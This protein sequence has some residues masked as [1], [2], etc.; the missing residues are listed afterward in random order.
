MNLLF[1][2]NLTVID[3]AYLD[4]TRG[5]V[6]ESW[7]VDVELLGDLDEQGMVFD[8]SHVKRIIKQVIDECIDHRLLVPGH[9]PG[10]QL[11]REGDIYTLE[12]A[13]DD[14]TALTHVSPGV[15]LILIPGERIE[16]S[17]VAGVIIKELR[18]ALPGNVKD[19]H[20]QLRE[21]VIDGP[22]YHYVHGLKKHAGNCQRIAHG[23]RSRL[24][25]W[26]NGERCPT[27]EQ[28][29]A[30]RWRDIYVGTEEDIADRFLRDDVA[31]Y[32]F[33]YQANQG[34]FELEIPAARVYLMDTDTTVEL[35]AAHLADQ[36]KRAQPDARIRVKAFEGVGKGAIA[37]R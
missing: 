20:I 4:A 2:D 25:I 32:R 14:G 13:L 22:W 26:R 29:W 35:I 19:V 31:Y 12:W 10:L 30:S 27:L 33:S 23:H 9:A 8:F 17:A 36:C 28:T 21:E 3:F 37:E 6:G 15:A 1:V 11:R 18:K 16:A 5:L 7:I 24:E 34:D